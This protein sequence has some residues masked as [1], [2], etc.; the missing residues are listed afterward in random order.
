MS[1]KIPKSVTTVCVGNVCR[2]PVAEVLLREYTKRSKNSAL[3]KI[4]FDSAGLFGGKLELSDI[5]DE[6]VKEKGFNLTGF[7]SKMTTRRYLTQFDQI[8]VME[9]WHKEYIL[10]HYFCDTTKRKRRKIEGKMKTLSEA[11]GIDGDIIDPFTIEAEKFRKI[12]NTIDYSCQK[13]VSQWEK[14]CS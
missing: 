1:N 2:S 7:R 3:H 6:F 9:R 5:S 10:K 11:A 8:L 14:A 12:L 13:I 4:N